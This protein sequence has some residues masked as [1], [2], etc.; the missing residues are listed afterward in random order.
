MANKKFWMGMLVIVLVF[1]VAKIGCAQSGGGVLTITNIPSRYNGMYAIARGH[2][3][4]AM[5]GGAQDITVTEHSVNTTGVRISNGRVSLPM[6]LSNNFT[7][8]IVRY[9]GNHADVTN[10]WLVIN[11]SRTETSEN[12]RDIH[13]NTIDIRSISFSNGSATISYHDFW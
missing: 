5:L 9:Y 1:G 4:F 6:W 10:M 8:E 11:S 13:V 12:F 3:Q 7:G 2:L